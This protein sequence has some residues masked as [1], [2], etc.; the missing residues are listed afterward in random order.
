MTNIEI[1]ISTPDTTDMT[2]HKNL[3]LESAK[4]FEMNIQPE[5]KIKDGKNFI[6]GIEIIG[7]VLSSA[8]G[9]GVSEL[10]K[11]IIGKIKKNKKEEDL[12]IKE[13]IRE[14]EIIDI[15]K[16]TKTTI[17]EIQKDKLK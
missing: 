16:G 3:I 13:K 17:R 11:V 8:V 6:E 15:E 2:F 7:Y 10:Y 5:T 14:V 1:T 9:V 12:I 4:S